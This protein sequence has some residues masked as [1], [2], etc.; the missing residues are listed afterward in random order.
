[1]SRTIQLTQGQVAIVDNDDYEWINQWKWY[2]RRVSYTGYAVRRSK[3]IYMHRV[4]LNAPPDMEVDHVDGDGLNNCKC[5]L[6]LCTHSENLYNSKKRKRCSSKYKGVSWY[7]RCRKWR[8]YIAPNG[9]HH[10]LGYFDS[11]KDAA[12]AY[13]NAATKFFGDFAWL[14]LLEKE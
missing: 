12:T 11:E 6:R 7:A 8:A 9:R 10:H 13:D 3:R 4:V 5:N 2:Y 1:M 14:N